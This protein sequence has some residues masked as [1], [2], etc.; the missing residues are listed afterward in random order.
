MKHQKIHEHLKKS[1]EMKNEEMRRI[2]RVREII[3][4]A[5]SL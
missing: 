5:S 2:R 3:R 1:Q 4:T